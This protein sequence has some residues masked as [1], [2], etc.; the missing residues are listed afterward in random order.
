M[1]RDETVDSLITSRAVDAVYANGMSQ[2]GVELSVV[3]AV[4]DPRRAAPMRQLIAEY[5]HQLEKTGFSYEFI[6]VIEGNQPSVVDELRQLKEKDGRI[7]ILVF[8]RW[9]GDA[10]VLVAGFEQASGDILLTLPAYHQ[11]DPDAIPSLLPV[12]EE[13]DMV[14]V[15]R[16]PRKDG[17]LTRI[18]VRGFHAV[19]KG[20]LGFD[21]NDLSCSVRAFKREMLDTVRI[22]GD[23]H[24]FLPVLA[25]HYGFRVEEVEVPQTKQD[26]FQKHLSVGSYVNR[27]LDL[28]SIFFLTK[29]TKR[30][31][32]FFGSVGLLTFSAGSALTL[33]LTIQRLFMGVPLADRPML[34][35]GI[36]LIVLGTLCTAIGLIGEMIVFT[37]AEDVKK[38]TVDKFIRRS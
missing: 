35:L 32:R 20:F 18:Q 38:Y 9:Y 34:L 21:F 12:L 7:N 2:D 25:S 13:Y 22:Y 28:L 3:I 15:R 23:Q 4:R 5:E 33:Y 31:L 1:D 16:W 37:H 6:F 10:T 14:V 17:A 30:P 11:I 26:T 29:F 8:A 19:L 24:R 27:L 36:L